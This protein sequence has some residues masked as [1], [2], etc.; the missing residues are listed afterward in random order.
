MLAEEYYIT[1]EEALEKTKHRP[2]FQKKLKHSV[3]LL[4]KAEK[5]ALKYDSEDGFYL[6][7]SCGKDSQAMFHVAK[8]AGVKFKAHMNF[9]SIDPPQVIIFKRR[10]YPSVVEHPPRAS[11]FDLAVEKG[12]LPS[13]RIRWCCAELKESAGAGKVT[14]IGI[15]RD[16]STRRAK[17]HEVEVI[18]KKFSGNLDQFAQWQQEQITKKEEKLMR[19]MKREGKKVNEDQFS[20]EKDNEIRC[21]NGKDSILVSPIFDW[22]ESD[23]WYFL[24]NIL[25]VPHCELYDQ[26][27]KRIG[28]IMCPM[29]QHKQKLREMRDFPHVKR[30]WIRAIKEIRARW[31]RGMLRNRTG[32]AAPPPATSG[33]T[34]TLGSRYSKSQWNEMFQRLAMEVGTPRV[35]GTKCFSDWQ[36]KWDDGRLLSRTHTDATKVGLG[37][38]VVKYPIKR[39]PEFRQQNV[40]NY[41][42]IEHQ[43]HQGGFS[44]GP[45]ADGAVEGVYEPTEDEIAEKIFDWWV[46]GKSYTEWY[47]EKYLQLK[48][49]FEDLEENDEPENT[50]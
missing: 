35:N 12:I 9:T 24:N 49:P 18:N 38:R 39:M 47:A 37:E 6:A 7:F 21:I 28:C 5:L 19:K 25:G 22:S 50:L 41:E 23:V 45:S 32:N 31:G 1:L 26:G 11:I 29:S 43:F 33:N 34:G 36:W 44:A 46:S 4:Q 27:Y 8:M 40:L 14:L 15:R 2:D 13:R 17:R 48:I 16:E 30:N 20:L 10:Q 3:E 42:Q